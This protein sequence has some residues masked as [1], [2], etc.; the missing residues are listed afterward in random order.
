M[1]LRSNCL[2]KSCDEISTEDKDIA[3]LD[4]SNSVFRPAKN[5]NLYLLAIAYN[6]SFVYNYE[7]LHRGITFVFHLPRYI[8]AM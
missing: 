7:S 8:T 2:L 6:F 1:C 3:R 4:N 5:K